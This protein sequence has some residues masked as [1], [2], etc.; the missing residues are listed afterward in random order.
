[1]SVT[2]HDGVW[3]LVA[4]GAVLGALVAAV[5][6][7]RRAGPNFTRGSRPVATLPFMT[8]MVVTVS[9]MVRRLASRG[10]PAMKPDGTP[11]GVWF[12]A[13]PAWVTC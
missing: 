10:P 2:C 4:S 1:M 12:A 7:V 3:A 13:L 5:W 9:W 8:V 6:L 11:F